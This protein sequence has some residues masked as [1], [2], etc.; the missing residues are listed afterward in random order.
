MKNKLVT[1]LPALLLF[2]AFFF[3]A[4][5]N[6]IAQDQQDQQD[7]PTR[8]AHL[9]YMDGAVSYE[10][11]GDQNWVQADINRPLTTG[12]N[13][14][15]DQNSRAE[16]HIGS[17][18]FRMGDQTGISFLNLSDNA[19]QVQL[20]QGTLEIDVRHL[21]PDDAYE[22]DTPN[23]AFSI[24]RP[25]EYRLET[26]P[27]GSSTAISVYSGQGVATGG[28]Q[29]FNVM[30]DQRVLFTGTTQLAENTQGAAELD[31][32]EN[33]ARSREYREEHSVSARY[34]SADEAGYE[35]LD[36]YGSWRS[37]PE[38]GNYW[39]PNNVGADWEPYHDGHWAWVAPWGWTWV[40]ADSWGFTPFHYGRW[41]MINGYW[42]WV[43]GPV[44]VAPVYAPALVGFVGGGGFGVAV[45][46]G[47]GVGVGWFPL[48]PRDVYVPPYRVSPRYVQQVNICDTRVINRTTIVNVYN[49]Y[50][51]NHIT[52]VNYTYAANP[53]AV[54]VVNR[55]AFVSGRPVA[56]SAMRVNTAE[57]QHPRVV[58]TAALSPSRA[59]IAPV[60][61]A[62][63]RPPAALANRRVVT[64]MTPSAK[65]EPIGRPRPATNPNLAPAALNR[66]GYSPHLQLVRATAAA[67][68]PAR[69]AAP[70]QPNRP[71]TNAQPNRNLA[72][73]NRPVTTSR[74]A[75]PNRPSAA[76]P[77]PRPNA[78]PARP[79]TPPNRAATPPRTETPNRPT[80]AP[81]TATPNRPEAAPTQPRP[82]ARPVRPFVPPNRPAAMPRTAPPERPMAVPTQP[83][84]N[85]RPVRPATPP[86][87]PSENPRTAPEP[88]RMAEPPV[89][90]QPAAEPR[91][92]SRPPA[93][94]PDRTV[95]QPR[96]APRRA[97]PPRQRPAARPPKKPNP[98]KKKPGEPGSSSE[99]PN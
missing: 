56:Q 67:R 38:Y 17:T 10:P 47:G 89:R 95:A 28:G 86:N 72:T 18:A 69:A 83:R 78:R 85:A 24:L 88:R 87:R 35:D 25:G 49:N 45:A 75:T 30:P 94:R 5:S 31:S 44:A 4:P 54:T 74:T 13:L 2:A 82:N 99:Q 12:D 73:P 64:K 6:A 1:C 65:A 15:A 23:L 84:P 41:A 11:S 62:R 59:S 39:V 7:P 40:D 19:V 42:G 71:V 9:S 20:A 77:Q 57:I 27:N 21:G 43:P 51:V 48:G 3:V 81:R 37:D 26:D 91:P 33:W 61:A 14:W 8:V 63:V 90:R 32:F 92:T 79:L 46:F 98:P 52:N 70:T 58:T 34:L 97:A 22:I 66:S 53:R 68:A 96:P 36:D 60:A 76:A 93:A 50:T 29:T 80:T 16:V 55:N